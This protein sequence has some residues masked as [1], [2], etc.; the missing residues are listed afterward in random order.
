MS[1][2]KTCVGAALFAITCGAAQAETSISQSNG[3]D[4]IGSGMMRL[5]GAERE[6]M[7]GAV[8]RF[9]AVTAPTQSASEG[10]IGYSAAWVQSQPKASGD[11]EFKCLAQ[12]IYFEARGETLKGQAAVGEVVLNRV[13]S[14]KFPNS[15]CAV[16]HQGNRNG[17]QFSWTC[18]GRADRI[19][20]GEAWERSTKIARALLD[21]APR[22][23]TAGATYFHTPSVRPVWAK[24]FTKTARIGA[25]IFYRAPLRTASN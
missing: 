15:V 23:L 2:F 21:G 18:D 12:A 4:A 3:N 6:A 16:V 20:S 1:V 7:V 19:G 13:D 9:D 11:A 8:K 14:P 24:R 25:H 5:L 22:Q 17:C 10:E